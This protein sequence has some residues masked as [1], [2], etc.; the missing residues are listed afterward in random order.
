MYLRWFYII[1][2]NWKRKIEQNFLS[3]R[4]FY[5]VFSHIPFN[6][7]SNRFAENTHFSHEK[8][9]WNNKTKKA[10]TSIH[11]TKK[12][13]LP[14]DIPPAASREKKNKITIR[15][16]HTSLATFDIRPTIR[17]YRS[18]RFLALRRNNE[19]ARKKT[20]KKNHPINQQPPPANDT[21]VAMA[22][23]RSSALEMGNQIIQRLPCGSMLT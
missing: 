5:T 4:I 6:C 19:R 16:K 2:N 13:Q 21:L 11:Q 12:F 23:K 20:N 10:Q 1:Q 7:D 3:D 17:R 18:I 15:S 14:P 22:R 8:C 9:T